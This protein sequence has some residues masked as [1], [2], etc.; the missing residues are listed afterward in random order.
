M[1]DVISGIIDTKMNLIKD[2]VNFKNS[3][4]MH[5]RLS[6]TVMDE[7]FSNYLN[8]KKRLF[9]FFRTF[10]VNRQCIKHV[11]IK[12]IEIAKIKNEPP[13]LE[14]EGITFTNLFKSQMHIFV[15]SVLT[16]LI[17]GMFM[18]T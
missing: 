8:Q 6:F 14:I 4:I 10:F 1:K 9:V 15:Q 5:L 7:Y 12:I 3:S 17:K 11:V 18:P 2:G 16:F 13:L